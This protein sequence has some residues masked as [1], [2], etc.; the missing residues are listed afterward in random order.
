MAGRPR[1]KRVLEDLR[2]RAVAE[3]GDDD[4][5]AAPSALDYVDHWLTNGGTMVRLAGD[6]QHDSET[7]GLG[8]YDPA[9]SAA[10]INRALRNA[11][12]DE[13]TD[14]RCARARAR[15]AHSLV[16]ETH[17]IADGEVKSSEDASRARN[18]IGSRQWAATAYARDTFGNRG[19]QVAVQ[20]NLGV[21]H[22]DALRQRAIAVSIAQTPTLTAGVGELSSSDT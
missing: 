8:A 9:L 1:A 17:D 12:G 19:N 13:A 18:R 20:V 3:L 4:A 6:M 21:M 7:S 11:F 22:L 10:T 2:L 14:D 5:T 16:E 15:G